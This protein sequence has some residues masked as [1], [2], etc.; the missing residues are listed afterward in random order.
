MLFI[1]RMMTLPFGNVQGALEP[2]DR[3]GR[4]F[5]EKCGGEIWVVYEIRNA[6]RGSPGNL[7]MSQAPCR[8]SVA[9]GSKLIGAR[10]VFL[11]QLQLR[12]LFPALL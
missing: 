7:E 1:T 9:E 8:S 10:G 6:L 5:W 3:L 11:G 2:G 4:H 12:V